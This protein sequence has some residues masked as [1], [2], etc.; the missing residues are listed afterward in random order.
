[1]RNITK[2]Y[3]IEIKIFDDNDNQND[4][5]KNDDEA[6]DDKNISMPIVDLY[7]YAIIMICIH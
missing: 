7:S 5:I 3:L 2:N 1:M 4:N 6:K